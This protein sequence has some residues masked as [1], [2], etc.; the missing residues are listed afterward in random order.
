MPRLTEPEIIRAVKVGWIDMDICEKVSAAQRE[1]IYRWGEE[2]CTDP[3]HCR[4]NREYGRLDDGVR[5]RRQC[6]YCWES[7]KGEAL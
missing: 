1:K 4:Q 6:P 2:T 7:L 5:K 3:K